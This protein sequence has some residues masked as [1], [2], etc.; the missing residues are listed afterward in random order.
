M[1]AGGLVRKEVGNRDRGD[2]VTIPYKK[3]GVV[4]VLAPSFP[5]IDENLGELKIQ[6]HE[7]L[8]QGE[9]KIVIDFS[10]IPLVDSKGIE[11]LMD[12]YE[13]ACQKSGGIKLCKL[14]ELCN[15]IFVATR[16]NTFFD[17]FNEPEEA[18]RSFL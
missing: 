14:N 6:M 13:K 10:E 7:F 12:I 4:S 2:A 9:I 17:I 11:L 5:L 8:E 16:M 1:P 15:D 3:L 18:A